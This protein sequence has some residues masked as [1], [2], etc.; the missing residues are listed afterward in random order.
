LASRPEGRDD[1]PRSGAIHDTDALVA[2][3][4]AGL[5]ERDQDLI[6][7]LLAGEHAADMV[8][9]LGFESTDPQANAVRHDITTIQPKTVRA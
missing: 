3:R 1:L 2:G 4:Q 8:A 6:P 5:Q 9:R 7:F